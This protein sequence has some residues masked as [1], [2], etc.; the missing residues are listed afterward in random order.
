M[1]KHDDFDIWLHDDDEL[2]AIAEANV[3]TRETLRC[4]PLSVV[5]LVTFSDG[6]SRVYKAFRNLPTEIQFYQQVRSQNIPR[7]YY[8]HSEADRHW[9]L[10]ENVEGQ[11]PDKLNREQIIDL[12]SRVREI[13]AGL[14]PAGPY[15]LNLS[16][17]HYDEF[18]GSTVGQLERLRQEGKLS[19]VDE[20]VIAGVRA[21]LSH[22]EVLR[23]VRGRCTVLHGDLKCDNILIR[24]DGEMVIIDWQNVLFGPEEI[25]LCH[26]MTDCDMDPVPIA[27]TG[28]EILRSALIMRWF[29]D[30][31]DR[32]LQYWAGFYDGKIAEMAKH[33]RHV[34]ESS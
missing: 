4:W 7:V 22:P 24:P 8:S 18:I 16:E 28:P 31:A 3:V 33:M 6:M 29:A 27:G 19:L 11:C 13:I 21:A 14:G 32:W 15:R 1:K 5:E 12:C 20:E 2:S 17:G 23:S 26:L 34:I 25:D 9:L 10:L 30:C